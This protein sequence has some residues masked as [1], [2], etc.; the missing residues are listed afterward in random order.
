MEA[1]MR[2]KEGASMIIILCSTSVK[3][4]TFCGTSLMPRDR[5]KHIS[6]SFLVLSAKNNIP[7][8]RPDYTWWK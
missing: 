7:I 3:P 2:Q 1:N 5:A 8:K 4:L 6:K